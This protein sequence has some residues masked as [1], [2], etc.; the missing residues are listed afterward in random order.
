MIKGTESKEIITNKIMK[1]FEGAFIAVDGKTI[2][3]PMSE[4][5]EPIEIKI[6]L[7]AAKDIE[8]G[9]AAQ[10]NSIVVKELGEGDFPAPVANTRATEEEKE[11]V[12]KLLTKLSETNKDIR[13]IF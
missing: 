10:N 11:N 3:V 8:G 2:R 5:G 9:G 1:T 12:Q 6:T 7:T 4:N 13:I